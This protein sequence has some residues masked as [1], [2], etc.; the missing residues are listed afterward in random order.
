MFAWSDTDLWGS[1]TQSCWTTAIPLG[2]VFTGANCESRPRPS[3]PALTAPANNSYVNYLSPLTLQWTAESDP[4]RKRD[5]P[6]VWER[7][8]DVWAKAN[9]G[10]DT[11]IGSV[12]CCSASFT[13]GQLAP[14]SAY[15]WHVFATMNTHVGAPGDQL[16]RT[17]S[18]SSSTFYTSPFYIFGGQAA[19][20]ANPNAGL[21]SGTQ[22]KSSIAGTISALGFYQ[23]TGETGSHIVRLWTDGG[24]QIAQVSIAAGGTAGWKWASLGSPVTIAA[25]MNY[26]VSVNTNVDSARK[27]NA[28]YPFTAKMLTALNGYFANCSGCFPN[29]VTGQGAWMYTDVSFAP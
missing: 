23:V 10:S 7:G 26:R 14:S 16:Y 13:S 22:F 20:T 19:P 17:N 27:F 28:G 3:A 25:N 8:A 24:T 11:F 2:T 6:V 4:H 15:T 9:G 5:V 18:T 12:A 29:Q 21:E 1:S